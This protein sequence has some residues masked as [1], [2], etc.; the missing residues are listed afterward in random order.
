[1]TEY[2]PLNPSTTSKYDVYA[3]RTIPDPRSL[4]PLMLT[5]KHLYKALQFDENPK[6]YHWMY[7]NTFDSEALTRRWKDYQMGG[8]NHE[9]AAVPPSKSA[10]GDSFFD[11]IEVKREPGLEHEQT[12]SGSSDHRSCTHGVRENG[13]KCACREGVHLLSDPAILANEYKDRFET[14]KRYREIAAGGS[15]KALMKTEEDKE[16][17][18]ADIW[19]IWWMYME[20]GKFTIREVFRGCRADLFVLRSTQTTRTLSSSNRWPSSRRS[21]RSF[22]GNTCSKRHYNRVIPRTLAKAPS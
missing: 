4:L 8:P 6:L 13:T 16:T 5:C 20:N 7:L 11:Q 9:Y 18:S 1:M 17:W 14:F 21:S 10:G 12:S 2:T 19:V 22:T 15:W 3:T